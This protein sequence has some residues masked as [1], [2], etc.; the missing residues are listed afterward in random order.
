[1]V[2]SHYMDPRNGNG[3]LS[4]A[5]SASEPYFQSLKRK[6][7]KLHLFVYGRDARAASGDQ[8]FSSSTKGW[9]DH[10]PVVRLTSQQAPSAPKPSHRP[11]SGSFV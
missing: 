10:T 4:R 8:M 7:L 9:R 6:K 11:Y 2:V 1:M 3:V 5:A